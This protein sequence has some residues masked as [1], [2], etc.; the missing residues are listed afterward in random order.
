MLFRSNWDSMEDL[1]KDRSMEAYVAIESG[2]IDVEKALMPAQPNPDAVIAGVAGITD[3]YN[4][5]V[6]QITKEARSAK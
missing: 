1:I 2:M 5:I 3:K 6:A 4:Q